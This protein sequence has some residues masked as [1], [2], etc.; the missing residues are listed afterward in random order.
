MVSKEVSAASERDPKKSSDDEEP[1]EEGTMCASVETLNKLQCTETY[2]DGKE[3]FEGTIEGSKP[4]AAAIVDETAVIV[5][6]DGGVCDEDDDDCDNEVCTCE[7][8]ETLYNDGY[9]K[10][11]DT[12]RERARELSVPTNSYFDKD[13]IHEHEL[14]ECDNTVVSHTKPST[15]LRFSRSRSN[16]RRTCPSFS[17]RSARRR[18]E[19]RNVDDSVGQEHPGQWARDRR[20]TAANREALNAFLKNEFAATIDS[21]E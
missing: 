18:E 5:W 8:C 2:R 17:P 9:R 6:N 4:D 20:Y 13:R 7:T 21:D 1:E 10:L 3:P 16:R 11:Y 19:N 12:E 14:L 15:P